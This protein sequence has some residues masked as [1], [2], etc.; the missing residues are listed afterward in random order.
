MQSPHA[1]AP[2]TAAPTPGQR[3]K[4]SWAWHW[5]KQSSALAR[6]SR[7]TLFLLAIIGWIVLM[8]AP[9]MPWGSTVFCG[10]VL[11]WRAWLTLRQ[12]PA[13]SRWLVIGLLLLAL[14]ITA[15][16]F[17]T[18]VGREAGSALILL[19]LTLKTLEI[20][21]RR[22]TFVI[23]FLGFF[24][25]LSHF[26]FSQSLLTAVGILLGVL[27]LLTALVNA[28]MPA[29]Y[30]PL[31]Q[32]LLI[33]LRMAALGTPIML[34]LFMLFPRFAPLW[35]LPAN[36]RAKTGLSNDMTVGN[37][38]ELAQDDSI[39]FR[40]RFDGPLPSR[41]ALYFRGPVLDRL[42]GQKWEG[43]G[44][45][46]MPSASQAT[47]TATQPP[48]LVSYEVLLQPHQLQ[49]LLTLDV[50]LERPTLPPG[51]RALQMRSLE[52]VSH[53]PV[54]DVLRYRARSQINYHADADLPAP[55]LR[56]YLTLPPGLNPRTRE[57]AQQWLTSPALAQA[58]PEQKVAAVLQHLRTGGYS[59]TLAPGTTGEHA[60]DVFWFDSKQGFCEHIANAFV[61]M[62][63]QMQIPARIVTGYQGGELNPVDGMLTVRQSD[64]HAWAEV[65]LPQKGWVRIDPTASVSPSRVED[66]ARLQ[67]RGAVGEAVHTINPEF[68][69]VLQN[70]LQ[71]LRSL[72][73]ATNTRWNN[74]VLNYTQ[75]RQMDLL[76]QLG[77]AN[78]SW[79]TLVQLLG[80]ALIGLAALVVLWA[81]LA[82]SRQDPWLHTLH[83]ARQRL[84]GM[85]LPLPADLAHSPALTPRQLLQQL[86]QAQREQAQQV[87]A[88]A[89]Q[90]L[91][92]WRQWLL[93]LEALRYAPV[94]HAD[95]KASG[96]PPIRSLKALKALKTQLRRLPR[97]PMQ[98]GKAASQKAASNAAPS[99]P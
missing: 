12:K 38:A 28:H 4:R 61:V 69:S 8:Q 35:G 6:E 81:W 60:A 48:E 43:S 18:I 85:G 75:D 16:Q 77:F 72:W 91:H 1:P 71:S 59:Y 39:A 36:D 58:S 24:T 50:A 88:D 54:V 41:S 46:M 99:R 66:F 80:A 65:W 21:A 70:G 32:A 86:E 10:A 68:A 42:N 49:W 23:F 94:A 97:L 92:A 14:V 47:S 34:A 25:L 56:P 5:A 51:W 89:P 74:W 84:L 27:A 9:H 83:L 3:T 26:L 98:Q 2:A 78:I 57:L 45:P 31:R 63:R 67:S 44:F 7:D 11:I 96:Q 62:M 55:Y 90:G 64:A 29:G 76:R 53:R 22:D 73:D 17:R 20:K 93:A 95:T 87:T 33:A 19:L 37:I 15:A 79:T 52:W 30:P 40:V 13:P 82:Q